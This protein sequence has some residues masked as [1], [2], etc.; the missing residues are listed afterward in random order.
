MFAPDLSCPITILVEGVA[1]DD[2]R[3][4]DASPVVILPDQIKRSNLTNIYFKVVRYI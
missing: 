3:S 2:R 4:R 1:Q